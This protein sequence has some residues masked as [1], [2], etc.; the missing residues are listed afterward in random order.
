M[1]L[2]FEGTGNLFKSSPEDG[3]IDTYAGMR[4]VPQTPTILFSPLENELNILEL[5]SATAITPV[6]YSGSRTDIFT[7]ADGFVDSVDIDNTS[8]SFVTDKYTNEETSVAIEAGS[9]TDD[10]AN[11]TITLT[12]KKIGFISRID[13][14]SD[15]GGSITTYRM[16]IIQN[17]VT[18]ATATREFDTGGRQTITFSEGNYSALLQ[19]GTFTI[20]FVNVNGNRYIRT[21]VMAGDSTAFSYASQTVPE[22]SGST[23]DLTYTVTKG[24]QIVQSNTLT[25]GSG[26]K[27][28]QIVTYRKTLTG[29]GTITADISFD[30]GSNYLTGV[31]LETITTI[32]NRGTQLIIKLNLNEGASSGTAECKGYGIAFWGGD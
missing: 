31:P 8:A 4:R 15:T 27:Q 3:Q 1:V 18:L 20:R 21:L 23:G 22:H 19:Q 5:Q 12:A 32:I 10:T 7:D 11:F 24:N 9:G 14:N 29:T 26:A 17:T 2:N 16:D 25:I 30:N 13:F 28:F 6:T